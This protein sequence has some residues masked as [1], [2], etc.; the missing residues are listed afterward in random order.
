MEGVLAMVESER[1]VDEISQE[2]IFMR[3]EG[4]GEIVERGEPN[5]RC[6]LTVIFCDSQPRP[7]FDSLNNVQFSGAWLRKISLTYTIYILYV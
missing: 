2:M 1:G 5:A 6:L 3:D 4:K 7:F